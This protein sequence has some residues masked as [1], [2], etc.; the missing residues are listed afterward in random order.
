MPESVIQ[1]RG[2]SK[3]YPSGNETLH[4]LAGVDFNIGAGERVAVFGASGVGKS[5]FLHLLGGLDYP[6]AGSIVFRGQRL[7]E[8]DEPR[9]AQ[10]RN[11][12]V[13]FVFQFF[14]LLPEFTALENVMMPVLIG[15]DNNGDVRERATELLHQVGVKA[16]SHHFPSQ[17]SGGERQRVAIARA[18]VR[19]P[20]LV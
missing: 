4:V 19:R 2:L 6:D 14:Q 3:S 7:G 5:T 10:Y 1:V 8:M 16:R 9:L 17:L 18:L 11:H 12:E 20:S 13:G 15:G